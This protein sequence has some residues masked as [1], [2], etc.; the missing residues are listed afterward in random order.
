MANGNITYFLA[1]FF[2]RVHTYLPFERT[3]NKND[4][5]N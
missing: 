5:I 3:V 4:N 1:S 2:S